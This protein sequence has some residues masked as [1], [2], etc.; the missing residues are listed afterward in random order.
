[1]AN[2]FRSRRLRTLSAVA[3]VLSLSVI[4]STQA[5]TV[6]TDASAEVPGANEQG[7]LDINA[8]L[9]SATEMEI[10]LTKQIMLLQRQI[11]DLQLQIED[12]KDSKAK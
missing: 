6:D 10:R 4:G 8:V 7:Q 9:D 3:C 1:M 2:K 12:L 5:M 11:N